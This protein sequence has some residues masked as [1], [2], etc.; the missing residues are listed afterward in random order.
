LDFN[1]ITIIHKINGHTNLK[2]EY[3]LSTPHP[4]LVV[5]L[6]I[7]QWMENNRFLYMSI[8]KTRDVF[9]ECE[10]FR[11]FHRVEHSIIRAKDVKFHTQVQDILIFNSLGCYQW[12]C[13][14]IYV[15]Y[16]GHNCDMEQSIR[17]IGYFPMGNVFL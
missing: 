7:Y 2:W 14:I 10:Q 5:Y 8:L 13:Q 15:I 12:W 9:Y 3:K 6:V 4:E 16:Y 17:M 11:L 1:A